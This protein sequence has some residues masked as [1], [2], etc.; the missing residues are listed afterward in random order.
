MIKPGFLPI[1]V[2][3]ITLIDHGI[4]VGMAEEILWQEAL[5]FGMAE[6]PS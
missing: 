6:K 4:Y 2:P 5:Q 1:L 3:K